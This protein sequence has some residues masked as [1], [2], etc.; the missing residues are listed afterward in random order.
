MSSWRN[1]QPR[2]SDAAS[3]HPAMAPSRERA[4][5]LEIKKRVCKL[6]SRHSQEP[7]NLARTAFF[8]IHLL[9]LVKERTKSG[10]ISIV[11]EPCEPVPKKLRETQGFS[12][13]LWKRALYRVVKWLRG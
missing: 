10:Q 12:A 11:A 4:R 6:H 1:S 13:S 7:P 2:D 8:I 5:L 9:R 3:F